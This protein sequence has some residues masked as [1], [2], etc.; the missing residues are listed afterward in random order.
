VFEAF[1]TGHEFR[2]LREH[3]GLP[4]PERVDDFPV[5]AAFIDGAR[6]MGQALR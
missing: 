2:G 3:H 5:H 4:E 1:S 6:R